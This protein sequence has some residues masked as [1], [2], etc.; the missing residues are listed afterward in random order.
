MRVRYLWAVPLVTLLAGG[1][2][3]AQTVGE[4]A[5]LKRMVLE[6]PIVAQGEA[7]AIIVVPENPVYGQLAGSVQERIRSA[8]GVGLRVVRDTEVSG[9]DR[10]GQSIITLGNLTTNR[11]VERLYRM[12]YVHADARYPGRGGFVVRTVHDPWGTGTNVVFLGGSDDEG[13]TGAV[14]QFL[15][16]MESTGELVLPPILAV[17]LGEGVDGEAFSRA[18]DLA[19]IRR[20]LKRDSN[21]G[22]TRRAGEYGFHYALGGHPD[23]ALA[24]RDALFEHRTRP[25]MG[26]DDTHMELWY[27]LIGFDLSEESEALSDADR[28]AMTR[29]LLKV[30]RG[31]EGVRQQTFRGALREHAVRHNHAMLPALDAY[32]G[33]RYFRKYY[34]LEE[35]DDWLSDA[36]QL[37]AG[38]EN[39]YKTACDATA[40]ECTASLPLAVLYALAEPDY[41]ILSNGSAGEAMDRFIGCTDNRF[42]LSGNG[43]VYSAFPMPL[44]LMTNWYYRD[45]RYQWIIDRYRER[46]GG[47]DFGKSLRYHIDG[48]VEP[49]LPA[50]MVG[51]RAFPVDPDFCRHSGGPEAVPPERRF[52]KLTFRA[53]FDPD[54]QY[55]LLDGLGVGSHGHDDVN[56][57]VRFMDLDRVF[58]VDDSYSEGPNLRDHN[59]VT[60]LRDGVRGAVPAA[61]ELLGLADLGSTGF[62]RTVARDHTGTDWV[63]TIVWTVDAYFVVIDEL[64]A[65]GSGEY[66]M[67]CF[68]RTLGEGVGEGQVHRTIQVPTASREVVDDPEAQNGRAIVFKGGTLTS[69][70][71]L[72]AGE[73]EAHAVGW[74]HTGAA[75]SVWIDVDGVRLPPFHLPVGAMGPSTDVP[76]NPITVP[77]DIAAGGTHRV[78]V[79]L[80]ESPPI[81][82]DR[83]VLRS[84]ATGEETVLEAEELETARQGDRSDFTLAVMGADR[85]A[86]TVADEAFSRF[87]AHYEHARPTVNVVAQTAVKRMAPGDRHRFV[88][89]FYASSERVPR[90]YRLQ[91]VTE[92]CALVTGDSDALVGTGTLRSGDLDIQTEAFRISATG[93]SLAGGTRL[94]APVPLFRSDVA[95]G[96]ELDLVS[97][98]GVI[99][100]G[101]DATVGLP[102]TAV[103]VDGE[104]A[105]ARAREGLLH[106]RVSEGRH[107]VAVDGVSHSAQMALR[108]A[109]S[110]AAA[111]ARDVALREPG[112]RPPVLD[113]LT[114]LWT[115]S[116]GETLTRLTVSGRG[117]IYAGTGDGGVTALT[118]AGEPLWRHDAGSRVTA[119]RAWGGGGD[120]GLLVGTA[121][122]DVCWLE[123]DGSARWTVQF[124]PLHPSL[125][126][127]APG[128]AGDIG[129]VHGLV[130]KD[131]AAFVIAGVANGW[132]RCLDGAGT[133]LWEHFGNARGFDQLAVGDLDGG[134]ESVVVATGRP[135]HFGTCLCIDLSG[136]EQDSNGLDGW[137]RVTT[138]M[139]AADLDGDG[140]DE[141][142]CGT[143]LGNLY[144]LK[145]SRL[146]TAWK[147]MLGDEI[148]DLAFAGPVDDR[149]IVAASTSHYVYSVRMG[150]EVAWSSNLGA[151]VLRVCTLH[152]TAGPEI[153]A[154]CDGGRIV[155]LGAE[156]GRPLAETVL[157]GEVVGLLAAD[158]DG[159]AEA[160]MVV[161][162]A[163]GRIV[164]L[165]RP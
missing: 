160:D 98:T 161:G 5:S 64:E 40:Y 99:D 39:S 67:T 45:G 75:N 66:R 21:R 58:L 27:A 34:G 134:G 16:T 43:D 104:V 140:I 124:D 59:A 49:V 123:A 11:F 88:N 44:L 117:A 86:A 48:L 103:R 147:T 135:S 19:A 133:R 108:K 68:W 146:H 77:V 70:V 107:E 118:T 10:E 113:G 151:R 121:G 94:E 142:V 8:T 14:D 51:A 155:T 41:G 23:W 127:R 114:P 63:R 163:D 54:R 154:A 71:D 38:Q 101:A 159:D 32:F 80:R 79:A 18:P 139:R 120:H 125:R 137:A 116:A 29:Y 60:V 97:G 73:Y 130:G 152:G 15:E 17:R 85:V 9:S 30:L 162:T 115:R 62:S 53:A 6:T 2:S 165:K 74:G 93:F 26:W 52:D 149:R 109:F 128:A 72:A 112:E 76:G 145:G 87:W 31:P 144:L 156:D 12:H 13:V 164:A 81:R 106:V 89:L 50:D 55:L 122:S 42:E 105:S 157:G 57:I 25:Y 102:G 22:L 119:L 111:T 3:G 69:E 36:A 95:V 7:R 141:V 143:G 46:H 92:A 126:Y 1:I 20:D 96:V 47:R 150:G 153:A 129:G 131:G 28:L 84:K 90:A 138:R 100:A 37:F 78:G 61:A 136:E 110:A 91:Q 4:P 148:T 24:C 158:V 132:L 83:I 33:G 35:A 82:L 56:A 65:Q